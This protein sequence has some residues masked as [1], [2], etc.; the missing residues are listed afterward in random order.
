ME[1]E[2]K[3]TKFVQCP[4]CKTRTVLMICPYCK[5]L[6]IKKNDNKDKTIVSE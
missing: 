2:P 5:T 3:K 6:L 4:K 1:K